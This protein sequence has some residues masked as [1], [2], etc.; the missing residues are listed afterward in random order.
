ML[1][2]IFEE[3]EINK[4]IRNLAYKFVKKYGLLPNDAL[5]LATCRFY[6]IKYLIS[7]DGDF[8]RVCKEECIELIDS[9]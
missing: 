5:I 2:E 3:L 1:F 9:V 8:E 6:G 7:F 4:E